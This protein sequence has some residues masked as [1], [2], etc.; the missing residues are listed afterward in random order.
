M[1]IKDLEIS[2]RARGCLINAGYS[3][4][5]EIVDL[6]DDDL[7]GIHNLNRKCVKEIRNAITT[8]NEEKEK[9]LTIEIQEGESAPDIMDTPLEEIGLSIRSYLC[10]KRAGMQTLGDICELTPEKL[11]KVRNLGKKSREEI[12]S[13]VKE[14]HPNFKSTD[15]EDDENNIHKDMEVPTENMGFSPQTYDRL[16]RMGISTLDELGNI[17]RRLKDQTLSIEEI[18]KVRNHLRRNNI[19]EIVKIIKEYGVNLEDSQES[20]DYCSEEQKREAKNDYENSYAA[21]QKACDKV[22]EDREEYVAGRLQEEVDQ[23]KIL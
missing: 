22:R 10:L 19:E 13:K 23:L 9:E 15:K 1:K 12:L 4:I 6:T 3:T 2:A 16:K 14:Y 7:L 5:E 20:S 21:W 17:L 11:M 18:M 8:Y